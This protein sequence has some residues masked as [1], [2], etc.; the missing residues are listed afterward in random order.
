MRVLLYLAGL[1]ILISGLLSL[2][3]ITDFGLN[4]VSLLQI[5]LLPF[6]T[7]FPLPYDFFSRLLE[8]KN[9]LVEV[10]YQTIRF[11]SWKMVLVGDPLYTPFRQEK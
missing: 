2:A 9:T 3:G 4:L 8:G 6:L 10:Y 5:H 11:L 1:I 7:S